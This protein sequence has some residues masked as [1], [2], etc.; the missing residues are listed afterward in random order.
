VQQAI[1]AYVGTQ[2]RAIS[3]TTLQTVREVLRTGWNAQL[4]IQSLA[5]E[6]RTVIGLTPRQHGAVT[7]LRER[8]TEAGQSAARV[9]RAVEQAVQVGIRQRALNIARTESMDASA[10][11]SHLAWVESVQAGYVDVGQIRRYWETAG[12]SACP[13]CA[14]IPG[15]NPEGVGLYEL[16]QTPYGP[17]LMP[18]A[19]PSCR[20]TITHQVMG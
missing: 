5:Q 2:I 1:D 7:R 19:H 17:L 16:F 11:G 4:S 14:Q 9:Q 13:E 12:E 18:T 3:A 20:C 6:L 10:L 15:M 8:L